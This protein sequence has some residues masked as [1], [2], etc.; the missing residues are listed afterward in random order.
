VSGGLRAD[1]RAFELD[2]IAAYLEITAE[3]RVLIH[4]GKVELGTGVATAL[5]QIVAA[6]FGVPVSQVQIE[7]GDTGR[8]PDQGTTAGSKTLQVA[9]EHL[10]RVASGA[11]AELLERASE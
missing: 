5:C 7:M 11:R 10:R 4:S 3:G 6:E 1:S 2:S 8:T 9:G